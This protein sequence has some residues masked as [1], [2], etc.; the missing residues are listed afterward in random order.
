MRLAVATLALCAV[1]MEAAA[2]TQI[3]F[4]TRRTSNALDG[5]LALRD[6]VGLVA[7]STE[8]RQDRTDGHI[9]IK[10]EGEA[11]AHARYAIEDDRRLAITLERLLRVSPAFELR[12]TLSYGAQS[13]GDDLPLGGTLVLGTRTLTHR[14]GASLEAGWKLSDTVTAVLG[15]S[16]VDERSGWTA[17]DQDGLGAVKLEPDRRRLRLSA[18]LGRTH[19]RLRT[20]V[21]VS[22]GSV[23]A[24][25][26]GDP[27]S[28]RSFALHTGSLRATYTAAGGAT[29]DASIGTAWLRDS[30]ALFDDLIATLALSATVPVAKRLAVSGR[31]L[32]SVETDD[33][34]DP[35]A[36]VIDRGEVE[37]TFKPVETLAL[38]AGAYRE[39]R[40]NLLLENRENAHGVYAEATWA[41]SPKAV[42]VVRIDRERR[43]YSILDVTER[44]TAGFLRLTR[45]L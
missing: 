41:I 21:A 39:S 43:H 8:H 17:F 25:P 42:F 2:E 15:A 26:I 3:S 29:L 7:F 35:L 36:S 18:G 22:T 28:A 5:P 13:E 31:M 14:T 23:A 33:T 9:G 20:S 12:G 40:Q 16:A 27:P 19:G 32:R 38:G 24:E 10:A 1:S 37:L 6:T 4:E 44:T 30:E 34:D 11:S 45:K